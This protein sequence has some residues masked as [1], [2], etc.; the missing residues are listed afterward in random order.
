MSEGGTERRR[1]GGIRRC[2]LISP[3]LF[4]SISLSLLPFFVFFVLFVVKFFFL[5]SME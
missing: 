3:S 4:L 1:D 5:T 2:R